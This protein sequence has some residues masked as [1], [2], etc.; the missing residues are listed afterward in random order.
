MEKEGSVERFRR[1]IR[2]KTDWPGEGPAA[3]AA[4]ERLKAFQ[5]FLAAAYPC[6]HRA[7]E[8]WVL[9]P[10]SLVYR[11]P[12]V[13][14]MEAGEP[15]PGSSGGETGVP[16]G[17][18]TAPA[19]LV[20]AHYDVVPVEAGKW[21]AD[22]F[23][24]EIKEGFLYGRGAQDMK[25]SLIAIF[26]A[27]EELAERGFRP[28]RDMWFAF[29]GDEERSGLQGARNTAAWFSARGQRFS[30]ILDEGSP[31]AINQIRGVKTPLV[32]FGV[33][34]KGFLSLALEVDQRPGHASQPPRVQAAA[35]LARALLRISRHPFP[36]RLNPVV[37]SF[38][39]RLLELKSRSS[40]GHKNGGRPARAAILG[41]LGPLIS[42]I[43]AFVFRGN[44]QILAML[45]TTM[46]ITQL[47]GSA[48][49][50]VM[51]SRVRAVINLRLLAP[52]TV[53]EA[54]NYVRRVVGDKGVKVSVLGFASG[55]VGAHPEHG[56]MKG[57]G[58]EEMAKAAAKIFPDAALIPFI[59][60][61]ST[62]SRHYQALA[63]GIFRFSPMRLSPEDMSSIHGHDERIS[64]EN[65]FLAIR[66]YA[67]LFELL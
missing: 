53:D 18:Q 36:A 13:E 5:D 63:E 64:L 6:F 32:L 27:A 38:F 10:Y 54:V 7:A 30:W 41:A 51:P 67:A 17:G 37:A 49:D 26:E 58:W 47:S 40:P 15:A 22:P 25:G 39:S 44:S 28:K 59:M 12:A 1:A 55:P 11:W 46:A 66:F 21:T 60:T 29:G 20:L 50:N 56:R 14:G 4:V 61:A 23:G 45:R 9:G 35:A 43:L 8:R 31:V 34:E 16:P 33:E 48:A 52:W 3:E 62:D 2:I 42:P 19:V 24:G 65:F 57:P